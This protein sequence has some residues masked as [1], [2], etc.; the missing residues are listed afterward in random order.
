MKKYL[1][2]IVAGL[3]I[4]LVGYFLFFVQGPGMFRTSPNLPMN[5]MNESGNNTY[6]QSNKVNESSL[7]I[8]PMLEDINP[9]PNKAEFQITAQNATK[10]FVPGV[11]TETMGYNG[12]YLGP[13]LRVRN[14]EEVSVKV[15]NNLE[16]EITTIHW[17]GLE[18][19]GED[20]GGP[21]SG[22]Q[23]GKSWTPE[24]T[25]EQ[26]AATLWYHPHPEQNTGRQVYKGLAGLF[27]IE[28][29]VSDHL[30]VPKDYGVN[31]V[32]L[33]IQDKRFNEDGSFQYDLGMHD[34]M[35]GLQGDTLLVNGAIDPYLEVPK[36]MMRLRILNG[37][38]ASVYELG[39]DNNQIFYQIASDGGFLEKP[40]EMDELK[41]GSAERAEILVD[42]SDYN[43]GD[44][45][46]MSNQGL[47]FMKFIVNGE[48]ENQFKIPDQLASIE[49]IDLED[50][51]RT[52]EFVFQGMGPGVNINGKQMDIN[53][54]DEL[55]N[56]HETEIWEISNESGMGMMGGIAH[57]FHAHGVQFQIIDR[58]GNPPPPNET[59]W[60]DTFLVYPG[61]KVRAIATFNHSGV[62]MYH[63]H[64][65]EHEDAGMMGQ[66]KVD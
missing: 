54:I 39:F 30:E 35:Q 50:A 13:V 34:V 31:D 24:F 11:K 62:F 16:D 59:G 40:I 37:S 21:H 43:N 63:C 56:L 23:P 49:K 19:D 58:D 42:F 61:E 47:E 18:V 26:S 27:F 66:F 46:Q 53:R 2:I 28:D 15:K 65:L 10:E 6:N 9:D 1:N 3:V 14:G 29:E 36:G 32:P 60:K 41:L 7:P 8:P 45:V 17:H 20:D 44:I 52:R 25:I 51:V 33:I 55:V 38:N 48:S 12:D 64:I 5:P 22:I 57:P 4:V